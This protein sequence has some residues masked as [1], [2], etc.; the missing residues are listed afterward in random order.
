[1]TYSVSMSREPLTRPRILHRAIAI[2]DAE[3]IAKLSMRRL[4]EALG[5]EAMSLYNHVKNKDDLLD[6]MI[7]EVAAEFEVPEGP[8]RQALAGRARRAHEVLMAHPWAAQLFLSRVTAG[9]N[10]LAYVEKTLACLTGAGFTLPQADHVWNALDAHVYGF[11]LQRLNFPFAPEDYAAAARD[12]APMIP[13]EVFPNLRAMS[14]MVASGAHDGLQSL[15]FGLE[16]LLDGF[17][18]LL[19]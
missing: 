10:H 5:V 19:S 6:G 9:P 14:D 16:F 3:G 2:A 7:D 4:G 15:D 12:Y 18:R 11:T 8:W 17:E 1:M 13:A